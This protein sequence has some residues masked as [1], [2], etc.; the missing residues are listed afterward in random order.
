MLIL[1]TIISPLLLTACGKAPDLSFEET[2]NV[3]DKNTESTI[4]ILELLDTQ[5]GI[6]QTSTKW[7]I[8]IDAN[9]QG[10][11][12]VVVDILNTTNPK[13]QDSEW[14]VKLNV[15]AKLGEDIMGVA[16]DMNIKL[17]LKT[18][19]KDYQIYLQ[20]SELTTKAS[21]ALQTQIGFFASM[22][23]G[24]KQKW[25]KIDEPEMQAM[26]KNM[27]TN[28]PMLEN[29]NLYKNK[30]EYYTGVV[31][32]TYE[33]QPAWKVDFNID[34]VKEQ[35]KLIIEEVLMQNSVMYTGT[36]NY[37]S[38]KQEMDTL[39]KE[40]HQLIDTMSFENVEA[41][42]VIY[43]KDKVKFVVKNMD[44]LIPEKLKILI[45]SS[46][47]EELDKIKIIL[48]PLENGEEQ[49]ILDIEIKEKGKAKYSFIANI[50]SSLTEKPIVLQGTFVFGLSDKAFS[51]KP[52][53]NITFNTIN[54]QL[55]GIYA[56]NLLDDYNFV[57]PEKSENLEDVAGAL[58]GLSANEEEF[59]DE[60]LVD[61][62][63]EEQAETTLQ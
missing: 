22:L 1:M 13:N 34:K 63:L 57:A 43:A 9:K 31:K 5:Q 60:E 39:V 10:N 48:M 33:G 16:G 46:M 54:I 25:L 26:I 28:I 62:Q 15:D 51:V 3:Y 49:V 47:T 8:S 38:M 7:T 45:S 35:S 2:L 58:F 30:P 55:Q 53:I 17:G 42:F 59:L 40:M 19:I 27:W 18:L 52:D 29:K 32:T 56:L 24:F 12:K 37:D 21:E 61:G 4:K 36:D 41:Y 11:G 23:E 20:L 6:V 44:L 14:D 50:T